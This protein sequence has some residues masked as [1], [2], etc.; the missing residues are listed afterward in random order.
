MWHTLFIYFAQIDS[1]THV[2]SVYVEREM[3]TYERTETK[4]SRLLRLLSFFRYHGGA[5]RLGLAF[6]VHPVVRAVCC[7]RELKC[8]SPR[9]NV[10]LLFFLIKDPIDEIYIGCV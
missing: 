9:S 7:R 2:V 8:E 5:S 4:E 3:L 1:V 10:A 6:L